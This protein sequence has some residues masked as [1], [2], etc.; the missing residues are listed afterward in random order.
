ML[1]M[2]P[3]R[4]GK[5]FCLLALACQC[6]GFGS[7]SIGGKGPGGANPNG[8]SGDNSTDLAATLPQFSYF[9]FTTTSTQGTI[10]GNNISVKVPAATNLTN[11]VANF[12]TMDATVRVGAA[13]QTTRVTVNNFSSPL[14]YTLQATNGT[15]RDY[16]VTVTPTSSDVFAPTISSV[17]ATPA[18]VS[19]FPATVTIRINYDEIGSGYWLSSIYLCNT[20]TGKRLD[21]SSVTNMGTYVQ[22]TVTLQS[23]H[24]SGTWRVCSISLYDLAG[25][26]GHYDIYSSTSSVNYAV[27]DPSMDSSV[28]VGGIVSVTGTTPDDT[29]PAITSVT[30][31]PS[32]V[33]IFPAT[34]TIRMY[35]TETGSGYA[36]GL[37]S[38]C[39]PTRILG[40]SSGSTMSS[41]NQTNAGTYFQGTVTLQNY[42]EAGTWKV[43][44]IYIRDTAGNSNSYY[45]R[46]TFS[47]VNY[48]LGFTDT[49]SGVPIGG[50]VSVSGTTQDV[51]GPVVT[52]VTATPSA[53]G[54]YPATVTLRVYYTETGSGY[55]SG[56]MTFCSPTKLAN[57]SGGA[58]LYASGIS[59]AGAY[60]QGTVILQSYHEAGTWKVCYLS[61]SDAA[62]NLTSLSTYAPI[63][64]A[65]YLNSSITTDI[66][67]GGAVVKN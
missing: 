48:A 47:S 7:I 41:S 30:A 21:S 34:V 19:T 55:A 11:L 14:V 65:Y 54:T 35:Y 12:R 24:A 51:T 60:M 37:F 9:S 4:H 43:C 33:N 67:I 44:D 2:R 3:P 15:T 45:L 22:A 66:P 38:L 26:V 5:L 25:N 20:T 28:P 10:S 63:S 64:T 52:S 46:P 61:I 16:I 13:N 42:H 18:S 29:A 56:S 23:Y 53:P 50:A 1:I 57:G 39:S 59:N 36:G 6:S 58:V 17:T 27:G 8:T 62:G 49:D 31:T 32:S 40:T